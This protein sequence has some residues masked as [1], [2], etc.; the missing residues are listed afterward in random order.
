MKC[1]LTNAQ[2]YDRIGN[3]L[4]NLV[5][6]YGMLLSGR[7]VSLRRGWSAQ[8]GFRMRHSQKMVDINI[9]V[10]PGS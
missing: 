10:Q 8:V 2:K 6:S 5:L 9:S 4:E 1:E 3:E 7:E